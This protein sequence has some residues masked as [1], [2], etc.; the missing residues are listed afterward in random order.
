M[1]QGIRSRR[2]PF[3]IPIYC[4]A[5]KVVLLPYHLHQVKNEHKC[6]TTTSLMSTFVLSNFKGVDLL[7]LKSECLAFNVVNY[8][9]AKKGDKMIYIAVWKQT[10]LKLHTSWIHD[11]GPC[12]LKLNLAF[13]FV[14]TAFHLK[15]N[16]IH[17]YHFLD[18]T[19]GIVIYS[20]YTINVSGGLVG[21]N[22]KIWMI[23]K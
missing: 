18:P 12:C 15:L 2:T 17:L 9:R 20:G 3:F 6:K 10:S 21:Q 19:R 7:I 5:K 22:K 16:P 4:E 13:N 14:I 1:W 8:R 23:K 11:L